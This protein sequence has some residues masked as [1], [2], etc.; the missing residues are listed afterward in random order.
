MT[1]KLMYENHCIDTGE[2]LNEAE[3]ILTESRYSGKMRKFESYWDGLK[4]YGI[5]GMAAYIGGAAAAGV[6]SGILSIPLGLILYAG[7]RKHSDKCQKQCKGD[8]LCYNKCYLLACIPVIKEVDKEIKVVK[9]AKSIDP[10]EKK[11][12][13]KKLNKELNKWVKRYN[14]YK[15]KID[16]MKRKQIE[17]DKKLK[18]NSARERAR[19]YGGDV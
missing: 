17:S 2:I 15:S 10:K 3:W 11:K 12:A 1:N 6:T 14:K 4:R 16:T 18:V 5:L 9:A 19:Y 8:K 13:L 7:Y